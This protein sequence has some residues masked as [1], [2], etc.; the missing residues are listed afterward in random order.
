MNAK[1]ESGTSGAD[2]FK[3]VLAAAVLVGGLVA[4]FA[5]ATQLDRAMRVLSLVGTVGLS[6]T[7]AAFTDKGRQFIAFMQE[8]IIEV[9][10]VVWPTRQETLQTTLVVIVMVTI[11]GLI[12]WLIDM[13]LA[14][15]VRALLGR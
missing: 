7:I 13:L 10:K 2:T 4:I 1:V 12:L 6:A 14:G 3:L 5:Y 8:A 15:S 11:I 9:R